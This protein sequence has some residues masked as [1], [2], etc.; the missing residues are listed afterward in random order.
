MSGFTIFVAMGLVLSF[1]R[2]AEANGVEPEGACAPAVARAVQGHYEAISDWSASFEQ[3][4]QA[5][6]F[7]GGIA[8]PAEPARR[9]TVVLAKPGRMRWSYLSP[10]P[11]LFVTD[12]RIVWM[13]DPVLGEAQRLADA[14]GM[15]SQAAVRFLLGAGDLLEAFRV[16][17]EDCAARPVRLDLVPKQDASYER[18][19]LDVDPD[20]GRVAASTVTDL[21]GNRTT[22]AFTHVQVNTGPD[23]AQFHFQPPEGATV[24]DLAAPTPS[25]GGAPERP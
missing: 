24:I 9:G 5:V 11:S 22:L 12:G 7:S 1:A 14:G 10:D 19:A 17:A 6:A 8:P 13:W 16:T 25:S 23:P 3:R 15:L 21:F 18:L 4:R 20:T 2:G